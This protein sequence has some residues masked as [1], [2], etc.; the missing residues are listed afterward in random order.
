MI[1]VVHDH[2]LS[3]KGFGPAQLLTLGEE[4]DELLSEPVFLAL[5]FSNDLEGVSTL[6]A[7]VLGKFNGLPEFGDVI[8]YLSTFGED[9]E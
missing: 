9:R 4:S 6:V 2:L 7:D 3:D 8:Q 1:E 5:G